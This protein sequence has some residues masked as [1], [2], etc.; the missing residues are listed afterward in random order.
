MNDFQERVARLLGSSHVPLS[1]LEIADR[2]QLASEHVES[3]LWGCP[4]RFAWQPG[5]RWALAADK[6]TPLRP[7]AR[8][9]GRD[10]RPEMVAPRG[11]VHLRA[12]T[13]SSGTRLVVARRPMDSQALFSVRSA[14]NEVQLTLNSAHELF[15]TFPMPFE[16]S[17]TGSDTSDRRTGLLE[18]LLEAWA[19]QEDAT[20]TGQPKRSLEDVRLMWGRRAAELL[21]E[22]L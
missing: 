17:D 8:V 1:A 15:A 13:L 18:L 4:D 22:Q 20:P 19:L 9:P 14:G 3:I 7:S 21:R 6:T 5:H 16:G 2:L 10:A 12:V 11:T